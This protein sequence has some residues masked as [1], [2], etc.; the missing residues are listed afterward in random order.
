MRNNTTRGA[1]GAVTA[2]LS[3]AKQRQSTKR[4]VGII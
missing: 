3:M 2:K 1:C 4:G